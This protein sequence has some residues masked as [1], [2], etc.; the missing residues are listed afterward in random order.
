ME[1][2][3]SLSLSLSERYTKEGFEEEGIKKINELRYL[4]NEIE[5]KYINKYYGQKRS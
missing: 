2:K 3:L 4:L 1:N 5:N